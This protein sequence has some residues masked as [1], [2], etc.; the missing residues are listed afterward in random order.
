MLL[1]LSRIFLYFLLSI[2]FIS[3]L[4]A[5][6]PTLNNLSKAKVDNLTD[7]QIKT[8]IQKYEAEG[9]TIS[10]V[11]AEAIGNGMSVDEWNKLRD[12]ISALQ[13]KEKGN[14]KEVAPISPT[15]VLKEGIFDDFSKMSTDTNAQESKVFGSSLFKRTEL[16]FEPNLQLPTPENYQLGPGDD[17]VIDIYG[18]SENTYK[19]TISPEGN[20][21]IPRIGLVQLS[22]LTIEQARKTIAKQLSA[23]YTTIN[24]K[25]TFV[26][27]VLGNIR[28][29]KVTLIGEVYRPGTYTLPSVASI[30]NAL[31]SAGGPNDNGSFRNIKLIRNNKVIAKVDIYDF[32]LTGELKDNLILRDQDIIKI[33]P[34]DKRVFLEGELKNTGLF[35][36]IE[37][38]TFANL[39][40]IAGGF[41]NNA[42]KERVTL[43]RNTGKEKSVADI[44][45]D[46]FSKFKLNNGDRFFVGQILNR[47][48]NRVQIAGAVFRPGTYALEDG[49]TIKKLIE[50]ADGVREDAFLN[51]GIVTRE[52]SD[53]QREMLSFN[54]GKLLNNQ[55]SDILLRRED[56]V[57]IAS[58]LDMKDKETVSVWGEVQREGIYDFVRNMTVKDLLFIAG[59]VNYKAEL[60]EV[61]VTRL[62]KDPEVLKNTKDRTTTFS[63]SINKDL[64]AQNEVDEFV[65]EPFDQV[66]VRPISG[67]EYAKKVL[68]EGEVYYPGSYIITS[69]NERISDL[70]KR[71]GGLN[72]FAYPE[73]AFL[74]RNQKTSLSERKLDMT[75][76]SGVVQGDTLIDKSKFLSNEGVVG[77]DLVKILQNPGS[78]WDLILEESDILNVP[79]Q[80]QTVQVSG[81]VF[82]PAF[83]RYD[84]SMSFTDYI[85]NAGGFSNKA[86]RRKSFVVYANGTA[87]STKSFLFFRRYPKISPGARIYVPTR[88]ERR[89]MTAGEVIGITTSTVSL[90]AIIT[91]L[92]R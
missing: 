46:E 23:I 9:Y 38:E 8:F 52:R 85:D 89:S 50:K 24:S 74:I 61:E 22:G 40:D 33:E 87:R 25:E 47:F 88:P 30:Y 72:Q 62:I 53:R 66:I 18:L 16:T 69:K 44:P 55:I 77:I 49:M 63:F 36:A 14:A 26:S 75:V 29:I 60:R 82:L 58:V 15:R 76:L 90:A 2:Y 48:V 80:L 17:I 70:I 3:Y 1:K 34:Y 79:R 84:R 56:S 83:V 65:L 5:Q 54:V 19:V 43:E 20:A 64:M 11:G 45:S 81:E 6:T 91:S 57:F 28:G 35:E 67:F 12:R 39:I 59:G 21:R 41:T 86:I 92:F 71:S 32:L 51:R 7:A 10:Q 4:N 31:N 73:G 37:G 27:V 78:K 13:L 68:V 42:Y